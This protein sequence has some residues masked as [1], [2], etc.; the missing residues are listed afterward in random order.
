[1]SSVKGARGWYQKW[2]VTE[3]TDGEV[4]GIDVENESVDNP[5]AEF[6]DEIQAESLQSFPPCYSQ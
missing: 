5:E 2:Q 3:S 1:M 4:M 6:L